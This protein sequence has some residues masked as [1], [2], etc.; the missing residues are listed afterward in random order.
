[1]VSNVTDLKRAGAQSQRIERVRRIMKRGMSD[2]FM[3]TPFKERG[4]MEFSV[5]LLGIVGGR[6]GE[7]HEDLG[8]DGGKHKHLPEISQ[9]DFIFHP[10]TVVKMIGPNDFTQEGFPNRRRFLSRTLHNRPTLQYI[11]DCTAA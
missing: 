5:V 11:I 2:F 3:K 1:M 6:R 10:D 7:V 9:H 4:N 8:A